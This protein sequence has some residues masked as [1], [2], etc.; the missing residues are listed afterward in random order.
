MVNFV[1]VIGKNREREE[2]QSQH[3]WIPE[4][5]DT[6]FLCDSGVLLLAKWGLSTSADLMLSFSPQVGN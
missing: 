3:P 6:V 5:A 2:K 4:S 1:K